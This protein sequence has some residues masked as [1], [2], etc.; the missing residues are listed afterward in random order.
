[1][2]QPL[3]MIAIGVKPED[4]VRRTLILTEGPFCAN[5]PE[6]SLES[7]ERIEEAW[8]SDAGDLM[9]E[10]RVQYLRTQLCEVLSQPELGATTDDTTRRRQMAQMRRLLPRTY[11]ILK[12]FEVQGC[13][14]VLLNTERAL[15][16]NYI[17]EVPAPTDDSSY[18]DNVDRPTG[19]ST[20]HSYETGIIPSLLEVQAHE[21][22]TNTGAIQEVPEHELPESVLCPHNDFGHNQTKIPTGGTET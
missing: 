11:E 18:E 6:G 14:D 12:W 3:R 16:L 4:R 7:F 10:Q 21:L 22:A 13:R 17:L 5:S 19:L 1:M 2:V 20:L 9:N 15:T 8:Q